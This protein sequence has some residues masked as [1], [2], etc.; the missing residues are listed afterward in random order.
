M[1]RTTLS[2]AGISLAMLLGGCAW[3]PFIGGDEDAEEEIETTE[4]ILYSSAQSSLR[5]G[6]Y[7]AGI[8]KLGR[9][10]A[11]FPFGRYAEQAQLE[12]IYANYMASDYEAAEAAADRFIRLHPQHKD[13]DYAYYLRGLIAYAGDRGIFDRLRPN[14]VAK[15]DTANAR[16]AFA[17]FAEMLRNYPD[18]DYA[19]DA[20]Q[21]MIHLRNVIAE[22]EIN[23]AN[24]YIS[25]G[26]NIAAANRAR[27]VVENYSQTPAVA[28]ALAILVEANYKLGLKEAANDAL[29][30]L[31]INH[32]DYPAFDDEGNFVLEDTIRNRD[33]S[34][35]N[36]I[37]LGLLDRP[38]TPPPMR[39]EHPEGFEPP[40]R[41]SA[42]AEERE[43]RKPWYKRIL[44]G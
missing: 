2:F 28:P 9:L 5:S 29:R 37:T 4:Q 33:R 21:R 39:I 18:S 10:E 36:V 34:W 13:I 26:A 8:D 35:L 38:D 20:R 11:R 25:R 43:E 15:R 27:T 17:H 3:M 32:P 19:K 44:P 23:V 12:L 41:S 24:Y 40:P 16:R 30:I 31:A 42:P 22:A 7:Q 14:D 1:D 6:N